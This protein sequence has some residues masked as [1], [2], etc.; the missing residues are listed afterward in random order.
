MKNT[1]KLTRLLLLLLALAMVISTFAA[2]ATEDDE[3][4]A[5]DEA[6]SEEVG[7]DNVI[8]D[9]GEIRDEDGYIIDDVPEGL[10]FGDE[11]KIL[12]A[13]NQKTH[14][15]REETD[16]S[17]VGQAILKRNQTVEERLGISFVWDHQPCYASGDKAAFAQMVEVDAAGGHEI[18]G[19][20]AYNLVPY[21]V[22]NKGLCANLADTAYINLEK[23]WWPKEYLDTMM[24]KD[25]IFALVDNASVG[26]L[27]NLSA[28]FFNNTML[29]NKGIESPYALYDRN[30]WTLAK[31][32]ELTTDTYE[33]K[34]ADG[35][36]DVAGDIFGVMTS[37]GA[38]I[39]CWYYGAGIRF[40][41]M[42]NG[43]LILVDDVEYIG[44]RIDAITDLFGTNDNMLTDSKQFL[45]FNEERVYF[46]LCVLS[47]CTDMVNN[48][49]DIDYGVAPNPKFN[50]E[51]D[52]YYT[53]I[54]NTHDAWF[55]PKG[56]Q[57]ADC[58]SAFIELMASESYRQV[59]YV[60]FETNLKVR[61][62]P[63]ERLAGMYDMI[64][65]SITFDFCYIYKE[66]TG[67]NLDSELVACI[68]TPTSYNWATK[69]AGIK[70]AV[71]SQFDEILAVYDAGSAQ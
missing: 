13:A 22:A 68:K 17:T 47:Q 24:Y 71:K 6:T 19:V 40:S 36:R 38:R 32:K 31:L 1:Q 51:Q 25:Q 59:N 66:V 45:A 48:N 65:D 61:Y 12:S 42:E 63:D 28:V 26:T 9:D 49:L 34:N 44:N 2:C 14:H 3:P 43:E 20:V 64:R 16:E 33:D 60:F 15:W 35:K 11:F 21:R 46:Y 57:D 30:E 41:N 52:R 5:T 53:H 54:P 29:E 70:D 10:N 67:T 7:G 23:P 62:A 69:W 39:T 50:S 58:S 18:D 27:T 4:I 56:V 37:T 8:D 55:F